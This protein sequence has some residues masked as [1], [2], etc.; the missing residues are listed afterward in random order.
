LPAV[1]NFCYIRIEMQWQY[2]VII[3]LVLGILFITADAVRT[4]LKCPTEK[5][6]YKFVP[7]TFEDEQNDPIPPSV[8]FKD[9]FEKP[10]PW[11]AGFDF[12]DKQ[13][14]TDVNKYFISQ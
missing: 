11:I 12:S 14:R 2:L 7:R 10:T 8:I 13:V 4:S 9:L 1:G 3:L 5:V 6:I